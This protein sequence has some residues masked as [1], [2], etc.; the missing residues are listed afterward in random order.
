MRK[1]NTGTTAVTNGH[2]IGN[3]AFA[4]YDGA[5]YVP[6]ARIRTVVDG[7]VSSG[8]VPMAMAFSTGGTLF[9]MEEDPMP[10]G[11]NVV[12]ERLRLTSAG[13]VGVNTAAPTSMLHVNGGV[14]VGN[15]T[16][17]DHGTG[18]INVSGGY[19]INGSSVADQLAEARQLI[20]DLT[21]RADR[22]E[23]E[24]QRLGGKGK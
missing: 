1:A 15:P 19:F 7:T 8:V 21:A 13:N 23:A 18:T 16:H 11:P 6:G 4:G 10:E 24:V 20:A 14:Q 17:G 2:E 22:L 3:L 9:G 5:S 12:T